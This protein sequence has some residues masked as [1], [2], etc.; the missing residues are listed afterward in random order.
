M[1]Q[2]EGGQKVECG[3]AREEKEMGLRLA[4]MDYGVWTVL[5]VSGMDY[6]SENVV[7]TVI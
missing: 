1:G 6:P 5:S 4:V 7:C 2:G 3:Q